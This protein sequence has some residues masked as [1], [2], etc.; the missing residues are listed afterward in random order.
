MNNNLTAISE[1]PK[2]LLSRLLREGAQRLLAEAINVEV[3]E[4]LRVANKEKVVVTRN[5]KAPKRQVQ[6]GLGPI[7][8]QRPKLRTKPG[9]C[10]SN[11]SSKVLPSY[12][13][14]TKS[15]E[16]LIP[17]LYLKGISAND[18]AS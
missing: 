4:Y 13:R 12:L 18:M 2:D 6:T 16:E 7:E 3:T 1:N 15:V 5:G 17:W 10:S 14:K 8:V 9:E 11:F